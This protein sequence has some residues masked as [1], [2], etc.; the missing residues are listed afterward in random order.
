MSREVAREFPASSQSEQ[1]EA[2]VPEDVGRERADGSK[3]R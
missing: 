1:A 3:I 2:A